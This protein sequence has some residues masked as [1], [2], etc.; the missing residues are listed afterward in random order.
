[1]KDKGIFHVGAL[2]GEKM[3]L[4]AL[5]GVTFRNSMMA[6]EGAQH[7]SPGQRPGIE[8]YLLIL[9]SES[10]NTIAYEAIMDS[11]YR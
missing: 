2:C 5:E 6:P 3:L 4:Y 9:R 10:R 7:F 1:M 11:D 8:G